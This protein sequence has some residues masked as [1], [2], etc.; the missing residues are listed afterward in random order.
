MV[1]LIDTATWPRELAADR[2]QGHRERRVAQRLELDGKFGDGEADD[3]ANH[4]SQ[5]HLAE[6]RAQ[7]LGHGTSDSG[8]EDKLI[9][10]HKLA[11][12]KCMR[13]EA[14]CIS[15]IPAVLGSGAGIV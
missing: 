9:F 8:V 3:D 11:Y 2:Q 10:D 6:Q 13:I 7:K 4:E 5:Q 14:G 1:L 15:G 12:K